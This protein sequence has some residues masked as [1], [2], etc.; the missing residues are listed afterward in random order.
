M[1]KLYRIHILKIID[2]C[3]EKMKIGHSIMSI[4]YNEKEIIQSNRSRMI[5]NFSALLKRLKVLVQCRYCE[6]SI[7]DRKVPHHQ[8]S[9]CL[10]FQHLHGKHLIKHVLQHP[11]INQS[12][13]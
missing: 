3:K 9:F 4:E 13:L 6:T 1:E 8:V 10:S 11:K 5:T 7:T 12:E 2:N